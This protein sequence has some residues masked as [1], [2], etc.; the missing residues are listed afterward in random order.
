MQSTVLVLGAQGSLGSALVSAFASAGWRVIAQMR[1]QS[2][3]PV[4]LQAAHVRWLAADLSMDGDISAFTQLGTVQVVVHAA[5]PGYTRWAALAKPL[6]QAAMDISR[7]YNATLMFPGNVYNFGAGMPA[8]IK[9]NTLQQPTSLKGGT[10]LDMEQML[11]RSASLHKL[12]SVV[13]RAGDYFGGAQGSWF[14][15][16][17]AKGAPQG[18]MGCLGPHGVPTPWAFVDDVA[19]A[20]VQVAQRRAQLN[21]FEVFHF[22]GHQLRRED[23]EQWMHTTLV[24]LGWLQPQQSITVQSMP[25]ALISSLAWAVPQWRE[26]A[27]MRYLW[28]TPHALDGKKLAQL[29]GK[30]PRTPIEDALKLALQRLYQSKPQVLPLVTPVLEGFWHRLSH[31]PATAKQ[32]RADDHAVVRAA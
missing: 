5:S 11:E 13:V 10:R 4:G 16:W 9:E 6:L 29:I 7:Y 12:R 25:W 1:P 27:E 19:Q 23:W 22:A 15:Q 3:K 24:Q 17:V 26:L 18:Q 30:E 2:G 8:L 31:K 20:F 14:D 32:A 21:A 28:L